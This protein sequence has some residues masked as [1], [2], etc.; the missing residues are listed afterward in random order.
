MVRVRSSK[1]GSYITPTKI[2]RL[3]D[4][5]MGSKSSWNLNVFVSLLAESTKHIKSYITIYLASPSSGS[6]RILMSSLKT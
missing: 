4:K 1:A 6:V 2:S 5:I 3:V